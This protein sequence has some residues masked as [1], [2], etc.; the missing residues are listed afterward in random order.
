M[1]ILSRGKAKSLKLDGVSCAEAAENQR[2]QGLSYRAIVD[3]T[4]I[5]IQESTDTIEQAM[6]DVYEASTK[7]GAP[8]RELLIEH[9][10]ASR[11]WN[12]GIIEYIKGET[13]TDGMRFTISQY[14]DSAWVTKEQDPEKWEKAK[15]YALDNLRTHAYI[16]TERKENGQGK[17]G[18]KRRMDLKTEE[19]SGD[20]QY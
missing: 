2:R 18:S 4:Q 5:K 19:F 14:L 11:K 6:S 7:A 15:R 10:R 1:G 3:A 8:S 20:T 16:W 9:N 13:G 17:V 12:K